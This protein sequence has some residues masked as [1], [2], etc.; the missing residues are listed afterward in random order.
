MKQKTHKSVTKRFKITPTGKILF[1]KT[2]Q[3]HFNSAESGNTVRNKRRKSVMSNDFALT[4]K[5]AI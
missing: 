3:D 1:K 5:R 2:G 4:I